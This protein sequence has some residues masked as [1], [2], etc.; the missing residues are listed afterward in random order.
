MNLSS[1]MYDYINN[2]LAS[3]YYKNKENA[4]KKLEQLRAG[5]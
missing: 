4:L 5:E 2:D 1:Q 3:G